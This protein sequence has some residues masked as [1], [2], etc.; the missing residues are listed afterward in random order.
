VREHGN[1][2]PSRPFIRVMPALKLIGSLLAVAALAAATAGSASAATSLAK[3]G[4]FDSPTYVTAP[5]ADAHR[6]FVVNKNGTINVVHDG[7]ILSTP[8]LDLSGSIVTGGEQGLLSMAF[9]PDYAT[10]GLFYVYYTAP[11][12]SDSGGSII[13]VEEFHRSTTN[14]DLANASSAR[15]VL[16]IDHPTNGNHNGG[17][18]QFG[19]DGLL[20]LGTGDGGSGNDPPNN[21]Q[22]T[23]SRLGKILRID[24][25]SSG[26]TPQM[27]AYGVRNPWRFSFDRATGDL[28]IGDVG[29]GAREEIDFAPKGSAVGLD[30]GWRCMEGDIQ[31]PGV[32]PACLPSGTYAPP[33]FVYDHTD[34]RCAITGGYVV[35][36]PDLGSLVGRYVY[37]DFCA[38][39]LHSIALAKPSASD[40]QSLG[41]SV[42]SLSSF[43]EDSCG[44]VYAMSL[45]GAV[46]R[47]AGDTFTPCPDP[48]PPGGGGGGGNPPP[49]DTTAPALHLYRSRVQ[50]L[51]RHRS[52]A[53]GAHCNE[54]CGLA[55]S[56]TLAIPGSSR[57]YGLKPTSALLG[58]GKDVRL[59]LLIS[60]RAASAALSALK[61][62]RTPKVR[63]TV[64]ARDP[65]RNASTSSVSIGLAR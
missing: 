34:G 37:G 20:Y 64:V 46:Y 12:P 10:S 11:R 39:V 36:D 41:L 52:V 5:P 6:V 15:I 56:G 49:R 32:S 50:H 13:T 8:F 42:T 1:F 45:N 55:A 21:A 29:Q 44:H 59:T 58:G 23:N 17:Q 53:L 14:G 35:R 48:K 54:L 63:V 19:P 9:A 28:V 51:L 2:S 25:R 47:L 31:T 18:L 38:G 40:D 30:Y 60:K 26:A 27:Y 61:K 57:T 62:H 16:Q 4:D 22:N 24:P 43:G 33:V 7:T 3:V 65:S